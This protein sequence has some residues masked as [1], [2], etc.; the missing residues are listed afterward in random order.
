MSVH[1]DGRE[2][3]LRHLVLGHH[4]RA[5]RAVIENARRRF[6]RRH[7]TPR[8]HLGGARRAFLPGGEARAAAHALRGNH[9]AERSGNDDY[10]G[11]PGNTHP[12]IMNVRTTY[13]EPPS[14]L[15]NRTA[16]PKLFDL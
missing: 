5:A 9:G 10:D 1:V 2:L 6:R 15:T 12:N 8:P 11:R 13:V 16:V 14:E 4:Q 3:R 7:A